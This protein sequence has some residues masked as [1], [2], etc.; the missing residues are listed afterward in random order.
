MVQEDLV[1]VVGGGI[2][3]LGRDVVFWLFC[4]FVQSCPATGVNCSTVGGPLC[5][6]RCGAVMRVQT[7]NKKFDLACV[8]K[9]NSFHFR[10]NERINYSSK[11][12]RWP[13]RG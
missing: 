2:G 8:G 3:F 9:K 13:N 10:V 12:R 11:V 5:G 4:V 6:L 7:Q 1:V